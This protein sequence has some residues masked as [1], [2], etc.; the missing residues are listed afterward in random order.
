M[1]YQIG[2]PQQESKIDS[3]RKVKIDSL[4]GTYSIEDILRYRV[5]YQKQIDELREEKLR[6]REKGIRDAEKFLANNPESNVL[7][8]VIMRLAELFYEE[9]ED[10]YLRQMQEY[11]QRMEDLEISGI[12]TVLKEPVKDFSKSLIQYQRII[13]NFPH[14][15][16]VDDALYNK[17]FILEEIGDIAFALEIYESIIRD[18]PESRYIP[19]ALMRIAEYYF[20]PPRNEIETAIE[21]Y[22]RILEYKD[23]PKFDEALY[24]LGWSYYRLSNYPEAVSYFTLLADDIERAKQIDPHQ[25]F[26]NPALRDESL[27]YIGISFLDYG[28]TQ[29]AVE[30]LNRIG[31]RSYGAEILRKIADVYMYEKELYD[32]AIEAYETLLKMYPNHEQAPEIQEKIVTCYRYTKNDMMAYV[33]RDKLYNQYKPGS[34]WWQK[35][36]D[37]ELREKVYKITERSLRDNINLLFQRAEVNSDHDLY[38]QVVNDN[39][40]YLKTFYSDSSAPLIHWNMAL[41]M[42]TKLNQ[43]DTAYEEYMKICDLYWNSRYQKFAAEN[44]I[45]LSKEAV[46]NDT[47]KKSFIIPDKNVQDSLKSSTSVLSAFDYRQ[48]ELTDNEKKLIRAYNNYIK[49]FPHEP[50]T[51]KILANAGALYYNNNQFKEALRYFNT[52][53]KHFPNSSDINN[54][55]YTI[56]ESYFGKGD[57]KSA[58]TVA[59]RLKNSPDVSP[60]LERKAGK[61]LAE[62]IFL[63]AEVFAN[64][65][66]HLQAGNEYLR[67]VREVPNAEFADLSLFNA[68]LEYDKAKEYSRSV[69]TYSYLIETR[70]NSKYLLDA[71]NNLALDYGELKE[72]KNAALTYERLASLAQDSALAYD[73]LFNSSFFFVKAEEWEDAIRIN[74]LFVEKYPIS[75]DADDLF[76]DMATYYLKLDDLEKADQIYSE[77]GR[78][79]PNSPRVIETYF[80]RGEYL[81][82]KNEIEKA[83]AEYQK[84]VTKNEEFHK[85]NL[86]NNDY[87]AAEAQ[88]QLTKLK[89]D[90]YQ[91]IE[92][93]LPRA[94][95]EQDKKRKRELLIEIGEGFTKVASFGTIRLYEATYYIGE[96]YEEFAMTWA[97]QEIAPMEETRRIV[98]QKDINETTAELYGKAEN[99]YKQAVK[100]LSRLADEYEKSLISSDS[101]MTPSDLIKI[102]REDSTLRVARKWIERCKEKISEVIYDIAELN[103]VTM[104]AFLEAP[105]PEGLE[106][107]AE[108]EYRRQVLVKAVTPIV[109]EIIDAHVRNLRDSWKLGLENQWVKLSRQKI[110]TTNNLLA[111]EY[112]KLAQKSLEL[113]KKT[114]ETYIEIV[115]QEEVTPNGMDYITL[116]DQMAN[117]I[118]FSRAFAKVTIEVYRKTLEKAAE[119]NISDPSVSETKEKMLKDL[120]LIAQHSQSL[121]DFANLNRKKYEKLFKDS[122]KVKYEEALFTFEDNYFSFKESTEEL[123]ELGYQIVQDM[124]ISNQWVPKIMLLLVQVNPEQYGSILNLKAETKQIVSDESWWAT[125]KYTE[126]WVNSDF[127][128]S[129]WG[130]DPYV[131][132]NKRF[133][134]G[135]LVPIWFSSIDTLGY[136]NDTTKVTH[137]KEMK[138]LFG[139]DSLKQILSFPDTLLSDSTNVLTQKQFFI[140]K[141]PQI[142]KV[143]SKRVYFRKNFSITGLPV[144]AD[145]KLIIDDSYNLF[146]NGQYIASFTHE[147]SNWQ[148]EH[149]HQ[150]SDYLV[151]DENVIAIEAIDSDGTGGGLIAILNVKFLPGWEDKKQQIQFETSEDKIKRNLVLDKYIIY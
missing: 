135:N 98:T 136:F 6:L 21:Y 24:R 81:R 43:K 142:T 95:L 146:F 150:L 47:T 88:F 111:Y 54:I 119:E 91:Q 131:D 40:K 53:V 39:R 78:R 148:E 50:E 26:S 16:L 10:Q 8:K 96:C 94:K 90:E 103:F 139:V 56:L 120:Y 71:M 92:L 2:F 112:D 143:P 117:L 13:D 66:D 102:V 70:P 14:S 101:S 86:E 114:V 33:S 49:L 79:F 41:T 87:Y 126:G 25:R 65:K 76:Y 1:S 109:Q 127:N 42:D 144:S 85:N 115:E 97:K 93:T 51:A 34:S 64:A 7:D 3:S 118:D 37:K 60:E 130:H 30:Y 63:A 44:A 5:Y 48:L 82:N 35:H 27:E 132:E 122:D 38:F 123:L 113:Y 28:G 19:D 83:I 133:Y 9:T 124:Q 59:R 77:Y 125:D 104:N 128:I 138:L 147:N 23:S 68:A 151:E 12:D 69:E 134:Q 129:M 55:K 106:N 145:I 80:H 84:A 107:V 116:S 31:G 137:D 105:I 11:D 141:K 36:E 61:R 75:R 100:I 110:L 17:G 20:N 73:A 57:Y 67:V 108:M 52:I 22:K 74:R 15:K 45:A 4:L 140:N 62:S 89:F 149:F 99:S 46:E 121:T 29:R 32:E 18:F 58:E 72:P